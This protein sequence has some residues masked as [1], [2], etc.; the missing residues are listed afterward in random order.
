M[1]DFTI[2][3]LLNTLLAIMLHF[4]QQLRGLNSYKAENNPLKKIY[5][6]IRK[7]SFDKQQCGRVGRTPRLSF[8]HCEGASADHLH[9]HHP[10]EGAS[11]VSMATVT[12]AEEGRRESGKV[13]GLKEMG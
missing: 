11:L 6:Y 13:N 1:F 10:A 7:G 8:I 12:W 5:I 9:Q 4:L 3:S 2:F